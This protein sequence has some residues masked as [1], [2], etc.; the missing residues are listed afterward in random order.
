MASIARSNQR[1]S[2]PVDT[3]RDHASRVSNP[4][5]SSVSRPLPVAADTV[6]TPNS[7]NTVKKPSA[8]PTVAA[9]ARAAAA[10]PDDAPDPWP[11]T[12]S[13]R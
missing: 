11:R 6:S 9:S 4:T 1:L 2:W 8:I 7:P 10:T 13:S 3:R 5:F 12:T